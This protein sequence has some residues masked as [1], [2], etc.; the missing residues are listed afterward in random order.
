VDQ[1]NDIVQADQYLTFTLAEETFA[2]EIV[3]VA[4]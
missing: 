1:V 4:K 3:K 2:I